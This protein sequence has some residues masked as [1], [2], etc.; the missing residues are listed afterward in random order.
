MVLVPTNDGNQA[1]RGVGQTIPVANRSLASAVAAGCEVVVDRGHEGEVLSVA[2]SPNG[3]SRRRGPSTR[4]SS[5]GMWS[6]RELRT[7]TG[8]V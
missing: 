5:F 6:G 1:E 4:R 8:Q 7:L 3:R 2:F